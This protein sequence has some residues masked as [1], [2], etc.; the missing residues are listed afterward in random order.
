MQVQL[1]AR[2]RKRLT[3]LS[4]SKPYR[5]SYVSSRVRSLIA[6]QIRALRQ[7]RHLSQEEFA[8]RTGLKQSAVSRLEDPEYGT[9]TVSTVL[10]VALALDVAV[11]VQFCSYPEFLQRTADVSPRALMVENIYESVLLPEAYSPVASSKTTDSIIRFD[12][13]RGPPGPGAAQNS[14]PILNGGSLTGRAA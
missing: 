1:S 13:R 3:A 2:D 7:K 14:R 12:D 10:Q 8:T 11:L 9:V 5:D 6:Y 4:E